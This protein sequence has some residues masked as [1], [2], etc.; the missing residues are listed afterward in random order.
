MRS[1]A[2]QRKHLVLASLTV[3]LLALAGCAAV[4]TIPEAPELG[5]GIA[6]QPIRIRGARGPL[7]ARETA[8]ILS[9]FAAQAPNAG[10]FDRHL[11]IEQAVAG[12][13][14]YTGN[15]VSIL[16]DGPQTFAAMFSA[17][18]QAQHYLYLE[19]FILEDVHYGGETL[20]DL[21]I[22]RQRQGVRIDIIYDAIGSFSTP[23]EFFQRLEAAGIHVRQF[24]PIDPLTAFT[25]NDRDHRKILIA[26]GATAIVG[27]VNLSTTYQS[28]LPSSGSSSGSRRRHPDPAAGAGEQSAPPPTA[29]AAPPAAAATPSPP[30][31][32]AAPAKPMPTWHDTDLQIDGPAVLPLKHLFEQ[33]WREQ[34]GPADQ[35]VPDGPPVAPQ[36]DQVVRI[37]GSQGGAI[38]PR[39]YATLLSAIRSATSRIWITAAY[40]VPT[41]QER[42]ALARAA[43][44]GVDVRLLVPAHSD[45]KA[46]LAVQRSYYSGL[47]RAGVKIYERDDGMLHSKTSVMDGVWSVVG[48]SNFDHRSVLFN[49]EVDAV[50][51]GM[52]TGDQLEH[53]FLQD[54]QHARRITLA[55]WRHR[56]FSDKLRGRFWRMWEQ[57]L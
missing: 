12:T 1:F 41:Y 20:G 35:L 2:P 50:V 38:V 43:R 49:D 52:K 37:I 17:I 10:A 23:D 5:S 32:P 15:R 53:Y 40:F 9:R 42:Q 19:Y 4:P 33:H 18:R 13:P 44:R 30:A 21:L 39:Y 7:S 47:L 36:G 45:S 11:A 29:A 48:S 55:T 26:D 22:A 51:I 54:L 34:G 8:R 14:L 24:N 3:A 57:L 27:G 16:R 6:I 56:P 46:A 31:T 28:A 25:L